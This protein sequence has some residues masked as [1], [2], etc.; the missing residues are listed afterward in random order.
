MTAFDVV[1]SKENV[2]REENE[3]DRFNSL[4]LWKVLRGFVSYYFPLLGHV[5]QGVT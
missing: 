3:E 4:L 2:V 5:C 1:M